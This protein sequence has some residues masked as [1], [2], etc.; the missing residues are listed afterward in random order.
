MN[1]QQCNEARGEEPK[2]IL[3]SILQCRSLQ[4][5][6]DGL[7]YIKPRHHYHGSGGFFGGSNIVISHTRIEDYS[8]Y[9][10]VTDDTERNLLSGTQLLCSRAYRFLLRGH[11]LKP[12][13][14][15]FDYHTKKLDD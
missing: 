12:E 13:V 3:H 5:F 10:E 9:D 8:K 1:K 15:K 14:L 6:R 7:T 4:S 11:I 2:E